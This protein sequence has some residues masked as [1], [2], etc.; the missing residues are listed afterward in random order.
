ML[1]ASS[2]R[3]RRTRQIERVLRLASDLRRQ[4]PGGDAF[5]ILD[6]ARPAEDDGGAGRRS[7]VVRRESSLASAVAGAPSSATCPEPWQGWDTDPLGD[8]CA[9]R[10][11]QFW[12]SRDL[13]FLDLPC[14]TLTTV[15][16][17]R[18]FR[19]KTG[20]RFV[21]TGAPLYYREATIQAFSPVVKL[22]LHGDE[23]LAAEE[24]ALIWFD[25]W[26][27]PED[28]RLLATARARD[29]SPPACRRGLLT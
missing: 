7:A 9:P 10:F 26:R 14:T 18:L 5:L 23:R 1:E 11:M 13:F 28:S 8:D 6:E 4:D 19:E 27:F 12:F 2:E 17:E 20:F 22:F 3:E 16:A 25:L 29:G 24:A 15:E 21:G